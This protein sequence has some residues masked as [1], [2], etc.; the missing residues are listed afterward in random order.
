LNKIRGEHVLN[1]DVAEYQLIM[2][3]GRRDDLKSL[4][5]LEDKQLRALMRRDILFSENNQNFV[6]D[7]PAT[8]EIKMG[9]ISALE[10]SHQVEWPKTSQV[11]SR[12]FL[13]EHGRGLKE[14]SLLK[15]WTRAK[16]QAAKDTVS[17]EK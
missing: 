7:A 4:L 6:P 8:T 14:M 3:A 16:L 11:Q 5:G 1:Q 10:G 9:D 12:N 15:I 13:K 2:D 17:L